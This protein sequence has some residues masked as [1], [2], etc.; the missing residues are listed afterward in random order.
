VRRVLERDRSRRL[1]SSPVGL[2]DDDIRPVLIESLRAQDLSAAIFEELP[3]F[4]GRA[5]ADVAFVNGAL[6][7]FEI[8][9]E[10]DSL[11]RLGTQTD[12]Y[13]SI[14]EFVTLVVTRKHLKHARVRIPKTWG[15][16]VAE[17]RGDGRVELYPKRRPA[18]NG[19]IKAAVLA[20][21]LWK[22]EC[23]TVLANSGTKMHHRTPVRDLWSL[24]ESLPIE[25]LCDEV[26]EALKQRQ[27]KPAQMQIQYDGSPPTAPIELGLPGPRGHQ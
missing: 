17:R 10:H 4:R 3:I 11:V 1:D 5:R 21:V 26:R 16:I 12:H 14:F 7:G 20:R 8:K 22:R 19:A 15:I 23:L 25:H 2:F 13:Q 18:K 6:C 27:R 9:S 24:V